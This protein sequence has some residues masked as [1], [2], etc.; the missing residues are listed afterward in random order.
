MNREHGLRTLHL[1]DFP[2]DEESL[3]VGRAYARSGEGSHCN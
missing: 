1:G 3:P 2:R